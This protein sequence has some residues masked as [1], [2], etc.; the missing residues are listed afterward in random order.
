MKREYTRPVTEAMRLR[1]LEHIM[2]STYVP[3][4]GGGGFDVKRHQGNWEIEWEGT[5]CDDED[6]EEANG[7]F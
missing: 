3:I 5:Y 6:E 1:S 2:Q 7:I 4:G